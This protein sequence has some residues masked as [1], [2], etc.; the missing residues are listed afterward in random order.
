[1]FK[2]YFYRHRAPTNFG[3]LVIIAGFCLV[4]YMLYALTVSV[5]K[6]Y[7]IDQH[8]ANFEEKNQKL[9]EGNAQKIADFQYYTS[10]AYIDKVAKQSLGLVNPGE[11]VVI[12]NPEKDGSVWEEEE[13]LTDLTEYKNLPGYK[14][15]FFFF[16]KDNP[17]KG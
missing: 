5:Y 8:I 11:K 7:Q 2:S 1:M 10:D 16:F 4:A 13:I 12:L 6:S 3:K 9:E 15:W 14:K 17:W